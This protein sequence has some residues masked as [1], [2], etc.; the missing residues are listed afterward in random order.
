M[1]Y[2]YWGRTHLP[3]PKLLQLLAQCPS[4]CEIWIN[5][6]NLSVVD[7]KGQYLG[8]IDCAQGEELC[9]VYQNKTENSPKADF[10]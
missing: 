1:A 8:Y 7:A 5:S 3:L 4:D 10:G 2:D 6:G 9:W